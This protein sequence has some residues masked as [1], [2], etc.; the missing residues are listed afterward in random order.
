MPLME[1]MAS[2]LPIA[3]SDR[4]PMSEV[5]GDAGIYFNP[6]NPTDIARALR[7]LVN[8]PELRAHCAAKAGEKAETY[9]WESCAQRTMAFLADIASGASQRCV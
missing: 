1:A 8:S 6:E 3:C 9:T 5:L 2:G 7:Q 4:G